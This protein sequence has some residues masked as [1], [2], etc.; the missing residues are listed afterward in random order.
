MRHGFRHSLVAIS[1]IQAGN[2]IFFVCAASGLGALL[3]SATHAFTILRCAG[4]LYLLYLGGRI[5]A[6]T[7]RRPAQHEPQS[8]VASVGHRN[9]FFH[10]LLVQITNPKALLFVS[11]LLP[12]FIDPGRPA[13]TQ[14]G[15]LGVTTVLVDALVLTSYAFFGSRGIRTFR[16]SRAANWLQRLFGSA[17]ILFGV[18]L[19]K[20]RR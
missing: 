9:L 1:G 4:A 6:S 18:R 12:Q 8:P 13:A 16:G 19:I 14:F 17:L 7:F 20:S 5:I 11:A 15:V 3:S 10:G 2:V